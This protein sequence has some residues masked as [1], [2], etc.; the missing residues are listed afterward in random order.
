MSKLRTM[1]P[2]EVSSVLLGSDE[3]RLGEYKIP[4]RRRSGTSQSSPEKSDRIPLEKVPTSTDPRHENPA[5]ICSRKIY[6]KAKPSQDILFDKLGKSPEKSRIE[7]SLKSEKVKFMSFLNKKNSSRDKEEFNQ[8]LDSKNRFVKIHYERNNLQIISTNGQ[9][10]EKYFVNFLILL[11][12]P[13]FLSR[14][15]A[16]PFVAQGATFFINKNPRFYFLS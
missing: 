15:A 3:P 12:H 9:I 10:M 7:K 13:L 11:F 1:R 4:R 6:G 14:S 5:G 8:F 2:A 16:T